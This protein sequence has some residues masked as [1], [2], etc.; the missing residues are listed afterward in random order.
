[1]QGPQAEQNKSLRIMP[2]KRNIK[3]HEISDIEEQG[4]RLE[5]LINLSHGIREKEQRIPISFNDFLFSASI[6]PEQVFRN[7]F[8]LFHDMVHYYVKEGLDEFPVTEDSVGF[9]HYDTTPLFANDVDEPFFSDRLF[10]NRFMKLA[11]DFRKGI[12]NNHIYLFEGP[13]GSGKSTFLNNLLYKLEHYT[14]LPEGSM[15]KIYWRIDMS[16]IKTLNIPDLNQTRLGAAH[17]GGN[18]AANNFLTFSCPNNDHPILMIPKALRLQFLKELIP[19]KQFTKRLLSREYEWILKDNPCSICSSI[20]EQLLD[21]VDD[22][23]EIFNM[24]Y[25]RRADF[26]RQF[27][28]GISVY[29]PGDEGVRGV[30]V[31]QTLQNYLN[32]LFKSD[33][34]RFIYSDLAHTNN[35]VYA[36]M[37]IKDNNAKRL[38]NLH[39]VIS[40]GVHKVEHIEEKISTLFMGLINPEDRKHYESMKSFQDRIITINIPYVLDYETEVKIFYNKFGKQIEHLFLPRVLRNFARIIISTRLN[41]SEELLK[42][43]L[44]DID[45]YR[46]YVDNDLFLL[47]MELYRGNVPRWLRENDL[48]RFTRSIRQSLLEQ[49]ESEGQGGI[50]GRVSLNLFNEFISKYENSDEQIGMKQVAMFFHQLPDKFRAHIPNGFIESLFK[51]YEINILQEVKEAIFQYN[52]AQISR[53]IQNYLFAL[54]FE[55][56]EVVKSPYTG[57]EL[58]I[59]EEFLKDTERILWPGSYDDAERIDARKRIHFE[60]VSAT[61]SQEMRLKKIP[62]TATR[63]YKDL[64]RKY[65]LSLKKHALD[66]YIGNVNFRRALTDYN[67]EQFKS[68]DTRLKRDINFMLKNLQTKFEYSQQGALTVARHVVEN[69]LE[70]IYGEY[71]S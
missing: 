50:S 42:N 33:D 47:K 69:D 4:R 28:R 43:W 61:M 70:K 52:D 48:K 11:D 23:N 56:G 29:N 5:A 22:P 1:M 30:I 2:R 24:L 7:V 45:Y 38:I 68:Y 18:S 57:D 46:K 12:Q 44:E 25:V 8:Q 64:Y 58:E 71:D 9:I 59:S 19:D 20:Y 49:S 37:D 39:G 6:N 54:N 31:N 60:F 41:S 27:G 40:D 13:P 26:S 65:A 14:H 32:H 34:L 62:L 3:V 66:P 67:T 21:E 36:L 17:E 35:G 51:I 53:S 10:A 16:R 63:Q 55:Y 15:Y